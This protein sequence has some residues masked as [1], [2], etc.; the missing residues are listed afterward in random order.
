MSSYRSIQTASHWGVYNVGVRDGEIVDVSP[1]AADP[2]PVPMMHALPEMVR[3]PLRIDQPYVRASYLQSREGSRAL[4]G[5]DA[6]VPVSWDQALDLVEQ[7]LRRIKTEYGN[8]SIYGGSYGWAS[9]GRLHHSPSVL[10]RFLGLYGGYVDKRG[11]H[12]F[13]AA[14]HVAPYV[15]GSSDVT[16]MV[17]PW[18]EVAEHTELVVMF[19]GAHPKNMQIDPGGA[20]LHEASPLIERMAANNVRFINISPSRADVAASLRTDWLPIVPNTDVALMIGL[21]YVLVKE[22]IHDRGF[23]AKYCEGFEPFRQYLL[24]ESDGIAKDEHWA[25]RICGVEAAVIHDLA[26]L[27]A[28]RRTLITTAWS[29][30]RADHGEQPV[31]MTIVL[32]CMLGQIGKPGGGFSL[33][34]GGIAGIAVKRP[35]NVPRPTMSLGRNPLD[36]GVP[37][38]LVA[39]MLLNPGMEMNY[40]GTTIR[41]PDIK[42]IYSAGGNPFHHNAN[43]NRFLEAWRKPDMVV[44]HEP[45]WSPPAKFADIV[46]PATTSMERNDILATE[47][48]RHWVAMHQVIPPVGQARNDF[49][50]FAELAERLGFGAAYTEGRNE[51]EWLRF[52]YDDARVK[53]LEAGYQ[54][55]TFDEFWE[56]GVYEFPLTEETLEKPMLADFCRDPEQYPLKTR[57]GKI[58][59]FSTDIAGFSYADCPPHPAWLEP[60]EWLGGELAATYPLHLLSNQPAGKLH[61]QLDAS[62]LSVSFKKKGKEVLTLSQVDAQARGISSG[63]IV[64]V[65]NERG[66]FLACAEIT[67]NLMGGVVS[68]PT[69]AWFDPADPSV[70]C[71]LEKH[72]NPNVVT[73]DKGTSQLG[74]G[75]VAQTVLVEVERFEGNLEVT[76]F[77]LPAFANRSCS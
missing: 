66:A 60:A 68:I 31:W 49:D 7:G 10:K 21:A 25:S 54:P 35:G 38:G 33:G 3:S 48:Q 61:S 30:Q 75:S 55:P 58:E 72:G 29:V 73:L 15:V 57:S 19:G 74:Q 67:S 26:L 42:L 9:A 76:A 5:R 70:P 32:A 50:I 4:R 23:I 22:G 20:V 43:L 16:S 8:E 37:V 63:D 65:F 14:M 13:G 71:S 17:V 47:F 28:S 11:N 39:D 18:D 41:M 1:F 52:M 34:P 62:E 27:M 53:A 44:V 36:L 77:E 69:G 64:R 2:A 24:G 6:F 45:W 46:L 40:N 59:I 51:Q 12:S 56:C